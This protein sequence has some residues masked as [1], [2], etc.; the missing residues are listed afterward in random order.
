MHRPPA[1]SRLLRDAPPKT[2]D[3]P[4]SNEVVDSGTATSPPPPPKKF[5][6]FE[7]APDRPT[8]INP[9][10]SLLQHKISALRS[11]LDSLKLSIRESGDEIRGR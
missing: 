11:S 9:S 7:P 2:S 3:D 1:R 5:S 4:N 8:Y 10:P 6:A